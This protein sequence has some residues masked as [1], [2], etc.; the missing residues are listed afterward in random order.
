MK[1]TVLGSGTLLPDGERASPA[2]LLQGR[3]FSMLLD[4]GS[5][6]VHRLGSLGSAWQHLTHVAIT[7]FH[8]DHVGDLPALLWAFKHGLSKGRAEGLTVVGPRGL[9]DFLD[10][11]AVAFGRYVLEPGLPLQVVELPRQGRWSDPAGRFTLFTHPTVHTDRSLA[12]RVEA[13]GDV[14]GYTGDTGPDT[15]LFSFLRGAQVIVCECAHLDP[16]STDTHLTPS[17]VAE[18]GR[19]AAPE[20]IVTTHAYPPLPPDEVPRLVR[21]AGWEGPVTA[22]FDGL[23]LE[24][25]GPHDPEGAEG[26]R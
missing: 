14:L 1:L 2:H 16:A 22:G 25:A 15:E 24:V 8:G 13:G 18:L 20:R 5:G 23:Q 17:G 6:A 4:C 9:R 10:A 3:G 19:V 7:H 26:A 21:E 12:Y 11:A